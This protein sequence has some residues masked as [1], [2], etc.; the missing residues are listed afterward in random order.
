MKRRALIIDDEREARRRLARLLDAHSD[1][2]EVAGEE[3][4]A[5]CEHFY[6]GVDESNRLQFCK[7]GD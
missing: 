6:L 7:W 1:E 4:A 5:I 2:I 3:S